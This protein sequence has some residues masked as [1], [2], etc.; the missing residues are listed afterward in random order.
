MKKTILTVGAVGL[1]VA[2]SAQTAKADETDLHTNE[3]NEQQV[4]AQAQTTK[5][6]EETAKAE[7]DDAKNNE[8]QAQTK[9]DTAQSDAVKADKNAENAKNDVNKAQTDVDNAK[10]DVDNKQSTADKLHDNLDSAHDNVNS[11]TDDVN[12]A[13]NAVNSAKNDVNKAQT[14]NTN[15]HNAVKGLDK[16]RNDVDNAQNAVNSQKNN[17]AAAQK[18]YDNAVSQAKDFEKRVQSVKENYNKAEAALKQAKADF[19]NAKSALENTGLDKAQKAYDI[20]KTNLE[21]AQKTYNQAKNEY[22]SAQNELVTLNKALETARLNHEQAQKDLSSLQTAYNKALSDYETAQKAYN[23]AK[24]KENSAQKKADD[25]AGAKL[26]VS[27]TTKQKA[28]KMLEVFDKWEKAGRPLNDQGYNEEWE[29]AYMDFLRSLHDN[30]KNLN[31]KNDELI[32]TGNEDD[33]NVSVDPSHLTREQQK[34][35]SQYACWIINSL[36]DDLGLTPYVGKVTVTEGMLDMLNILNGNMNNAHKFGVQVAYDNDHNVG[37]VSNMYEL[38]LSLKES[39]WRLVT[40]DLDFHQTGHVMSLTGIDNLNNY[41]K[42]SETFLGATTHYGTE[43]EVSASNPNGQ[44]T[45]NIWD[46]YLVSNLRSKVTGEFIP[47]QAINGKTAEENEKIFT[48]KGGF[49]KI[50]NPYESVISELVNAKKQTQSAEASLAT[51]EKTK[52]LAESYLN[53][54]KN[55]VQSTLN[56][57]NSAQAKVDQAKKLVLERNQSWHDAKVAL[58]NAQS[59]FDQ[60]ERA[61]S[62]YIADKQQKQENYDKARIAYNKAQK[63]YNSAKRER[64]GALS[65]L[66]I[67]ER[68][69]AEVRTLL[70]TQKAELAKNEKAL[71]DAQTELDNAGKAYQKAKAAVLANQNF[72]MTTDEKDT[73]IMAQNQLAQAQ[74]KL[75]EA[76][77]TLVEK[78]KALESAKEDLA[79]SETEYANAKIALETAQKEL[80]V[81]EQ[82]LENLKNAPEIYEKAKA[83][84]DNAVKVLEQAKAQTAL[85]QKAYDTL[86]AQLEFENAVKK[87]QAKLNDKTSHTDTTPLVLKK[88]GNSKTDNGVAGVS[89]ATGR[90]DTVKSNDLPQMGE[91]DSDAATAGVIMTMFAGILAMLGLSDRRKA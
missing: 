19:E 23:T 72:R 17:V 84:Y 44:Y 63:N 50:D 29:N 67:F 61:L 88:S 40:N 77:K 79:Q 27:E 82:V 22:D 66:A 55:K 90:K 78:Q 12:K 86:K 11:K 35:I 6:K 26:L 24:E 65:D 2:G 1:A 13:Q 59:D 54:Q 32:F 7:L 53:A 49:S 28:K 41:G 91:K 20:A 15:A 9:A 25:L 33:K 58:D 4:Q 83:D 60:A 16:A 80:E 21:N 68:Q 52:N 57:V 37:Y 14:N 34:E 48:E 31:V 42:C 76:Q 51:A 3:V 10:T 87:E 71:A 39:I 73:L 43:G 85:K 18:N 38:K 70:D 8:Q 46:F 62:F 75:S 45:G 89:F 30:E 74:K 56:D 64:D 69:F 81:R 47:S 36:R 5:Q